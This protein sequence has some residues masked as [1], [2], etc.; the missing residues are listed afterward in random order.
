MRIGVSI[1]AVCGLAVAIWT[2]I[3]YLPSA[4]TTTQRFR[5]G[6]LGSLKDERFLVYRYAMDSA[7]ILFGSS[8][9]GILF[10]TIVVWGV[11]GSL[12]FALSFPVR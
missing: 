1:G 3:I 7:T 4:V 10:S 9:W 11:V 6:V 12:V 8:F 5:R 2:A